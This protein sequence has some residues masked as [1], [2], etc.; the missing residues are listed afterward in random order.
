[1][2][3]VRNTGWLYSHYDGDGGSESPL[4]KALFGSGAL[5]AGVWFLIRRQLRKYMK[6]H[7][8]KLR[9]ASSAAST[10]GSPSSL[11]AAPA[12]RWRR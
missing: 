3:T 7:L 10:T 8:A 4:V 12:C 11:A 2:A 9:R 1:M 6:F 5:G